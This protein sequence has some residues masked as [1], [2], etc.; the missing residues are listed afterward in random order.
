VEPSTRGLNGTVKWIGGLV[1]TLP[2]MM[3][4]WIP[5]RAES[6]TA[7]FNMWRKILEPNAYMSIGMRENVYLVT[8]MI[9]IGIFLTYSVKEKL[10]PK[11]QRDRWLI[12]VGDTSVIALVVALVIVFLRP[13]NQ[14][15][16][17]QF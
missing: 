13:I 2:L 1:L 14:F 16:Y 11:V 10:L 15:I 17:F 6:L 4:S 3:L 9:L 5:I 8:A 12:F 7:A